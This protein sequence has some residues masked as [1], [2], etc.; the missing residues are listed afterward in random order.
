M[1]GNGVFSVVGKRRYFAKTYQE[2]MEIIEN[3]DDISE[4]L[5]EMR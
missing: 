2:A 3:F 1:D 4:I 5:E